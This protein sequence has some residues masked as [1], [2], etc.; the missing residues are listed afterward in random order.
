MAILCHF[1]A[2]GVC[3]NGDSCKFVHQQD[4][5]S[6]KSSHPAASQSS[7][8]VQSRPSRSLPNDS[9]I[10]EQVSPRETSDTCTTVP[11]R[12][13]LRPE[14]CQNASCTFLHEL[15]GRRERASDPTLD[16]SLPTQTSSDTRGSIPCKYVAFPS[17]CQKDTC[18]FLHVTNGQAVLDETK[19][20]LGDES[21]ARRYLF[22]V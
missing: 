9:G 20:Y 15:E 8:C 1:F 16:G 21:E 11:C 4:V 22:Y 12:F 7:W 17:G 2:R 3:K 18:P 19:T 6:Q 10:S 13:F 5:S 14:G